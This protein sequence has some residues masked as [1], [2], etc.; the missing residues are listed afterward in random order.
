LEFSCG[1]EAASI[2][3]R[4]ILSI[5]LGV[6]RVSNLQ[7]LQVLDS[8]LDAIRVRLE[9][10][11][12]DLSSSPEV[13]AARQEASSAERDL[14]SARGL[15]RDLEDQVAS[16][17]AKL[18]ETT[19]RLYSGEV[20]NPKELLDLQNEEAALRHQIAVLEERQL[21]Q[22]LAVDD[23]QSA[24]VRTGAHLH[25]AEAHR[26]NQSARLL[27]EKKELLTRRDTLET[28]R[29]A[30]IAVIH[31]EDLQTYARVRETHRGLAV[32]RIE[33][34]VCGACGVAPS[35]ARIEQARSGEQIVFC[36]NCGRILYAG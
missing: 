12:R 30:G 21:E 23:R 14:K 5:I 3:G 29:E 36:G 9:E 28:Q 20:K 33:G 7:R 11:D 16:Q 2:D 19:H 13:E 27:Q 25:E 18:E 8:E 22:M 1:G 24:S 4:A 10:I 26:Q 17:K 15:L 32:A 34:G 31:G 35:Q 6:S